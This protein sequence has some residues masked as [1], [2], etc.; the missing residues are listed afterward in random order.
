MGASF[1][2]TILEDKSYICLRHILLDTGRTPIFSYSVL[3]KC[4]FVTPCQYSLLLTS[5]VR[6]LHLEPTVTKHLQCCHIPC[7]RTSILFC[8]YRAVTRHPC[9]PLPCCR[10]SI[11]T[12]MTVYMTPWK[13]NNKRRKMRRL[14]VPSMPVGT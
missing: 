2:H 11:F 8:P 14:R 1:Q 5:M 3:L 6:L 4:V 10:T 9:C 13:R 7:F 12:Y